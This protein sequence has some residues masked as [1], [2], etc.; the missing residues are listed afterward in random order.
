MEQP[1]DLRGIVTRGDQLGHDVAVR[2]RFGVLEFAGGLGQQRGSAAQV[3]GG[4]SEIAPVAT[5]DRLSARRY[6]VELPLTRRGSTNHD[7]KQQP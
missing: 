6:P 2:A 4:V 1:G 3:I 5:T 7:A